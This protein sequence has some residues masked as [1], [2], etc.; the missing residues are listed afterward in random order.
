MLIIDGESFPADAIVELGREADF[1]YKYAER[2]ES[3]DLESELIGVF[4]NHSM[5]ISNI[6]DPLLYERLYNK[7]TEPVERHSITVPGNNG[8]YT[9]DAYMGKVSDR[10]KLARDGVYH[11]G[12]LT[13]NFKAIKPSRRG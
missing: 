11:W 5:K 1:L 12:D 2:T 8:A 13:V 9:Y 4:V 6:N 7:L 3:G 10:L